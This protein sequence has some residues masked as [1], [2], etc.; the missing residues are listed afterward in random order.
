MSLNKSYIYIRDNIWY[1]SEN[2]FKVGITNSIKDISNTYITGELYKG[3]YVK[4]YELNV[5][6]QKLKLIDNLFKK[7]FKHL[8]IYFD[9]G[10]EFYDRCIINHIETFF[11]NNNLDFI[12][13][14]ED[15]IKIIELI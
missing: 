2:I 3:F 1:N 4:I 7:D 11:I 12:S 9:G 8:N 6:P 10:T 15:E 14:T 5:N 13:K